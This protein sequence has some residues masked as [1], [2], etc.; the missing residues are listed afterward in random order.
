MLL[1]NGPKQFCK[2]FRLN[3]D[4]R[5]LFKK[6]SAPREVKHSS[7]QICRKHNFFF[8]YVRNP[9]SNFQ[10][11]GQQAIF[12][13]ISGNRAIY[14]QI[15]GEHFLTCVGNIRSSYHICG[16]YTLYLLPMY[17]LYLSQIW[18]TRSSTFQICEKRFSRS[19]HLDK[20]NRIHSRD[21][22][23]ALSGLI[24]LRRRGTFSGQL[25]LKAA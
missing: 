17:A 18:Q 2:W 11:C 16:K 21:T 24:S 15:C 23:P 1:I 19:D 9:H 22:F 4:I 20:H 14:F 13:Q 10:K 12:F 5:V 3:V 7:F 8:W 6:I 25:V